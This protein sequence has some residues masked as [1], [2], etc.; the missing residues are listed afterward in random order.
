MAWPIDAIIRTYGALSQV[1]SSDLNAI[2]NRIVDLHRPRI[3]PI[4][5]A[6]PEA[7]LGVWGWVFDNVVPVNGWMC[8]TVASPLV[9]GIPIPDGAKLKK[10]QIKVYSSGAASIEAHLYELDHKIE[11]ATTAPVNGSSLAY[12]AAA[13]SAAWDTLLLDLTD[14]EMVDYCQI[15]VRVTTPS[16]GDQVAAVYATYE[17]ITPTP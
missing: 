4:T 8:V 7:P 14:Q 1:F 9:I 16:P 2:Q 11:A 10:V 15:I 5:A 3:V 6:T 12:D 13:G 17:P